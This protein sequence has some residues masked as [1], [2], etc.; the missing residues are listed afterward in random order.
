MRRQHAV[1]V[2]SLL[3]LLVLGSLSACVPA[4]SGHGGH[5]AGP[6]RT[7]AM[8]Q[9]A[10][11][12]GGTGMKLADGIGGTGMKV[13]DGV[14][15]TGQKLAD[16]IGGTGII[17]TVTDF[18]SIWVNKAHVHL[19]QAQI[20]QNGVAAAEADLRLGQVVAVLSMPRR[21]EF[22]AVSVD[23]VHEVVGP[24]SSAD[25][26]AGHVTILGQSVLVAEKTRIAA[27]SGEALDLSGVTEGSWWRV[28]GLRRGDGVIMASRLDRLP[29]G[30]HRAEVIGLVSDGHIGRQAI[31]LPDGL[32]AY[33]SS[34]RTLVTGHLEKDVLVVESIDKDGVSKV[35]ER[36]SELIMEGFLFD[37]I[38]DG[39]IVVGGVELVLPD[40]LDLQ[41]ELD[42]PVYVDAELGDDEL[43]YTDG[44]EAI[45]LGAEEYMDF[46][47]GELQDGIID[48]DALE[49]WADEP[50]LP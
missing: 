33:A 10:D 40:G 24:V 34:S 6:S 14:G 42:E 11:G 37:H 8:M 1:A 26:S 47:E 29:P 4:R 13:A 36:A 46:Y 15:G 48:L 28:S 45:P 35:L 39:D 30:A 23:I 18:G 31:T 5:V 32:K 22:D 27:E 41:L 25:P 3:C 21:G 16:G 9:T 49:Q 17:G 7:G 44:F 38:A 2:W 12:V 50:L 19:E 20:S 43:F